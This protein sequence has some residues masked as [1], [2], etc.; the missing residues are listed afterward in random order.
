MSTTTTLMSVPSPYP[1]L[2]GSTAS[3]LPG[4][5][6]T[7]L[8][9][10]TRR[11]SPSP[12]RTPRPKTEHVVELSNNSGMGGASSKKSKPW[13][14]LKV[15]SNAR[16]SKSLPAFVEGERLT[17]SVTLDLGS[18]SWMSGNSGHGDAITS[19]KVIIRG[20]FASGNNSMEGNK[21]FFEMTTEVWTKDAHNTKLSGVQHWPFSISL[22]KNVFPSGDDISELSY[23]LPHTFLER[24]TGA[25]I[26]YDLMVHIV[27][28]KLRPNSNL[29]QTFV[30]IPAIRPDP[31][32]LLRQL[33][34]QEHSPLAGPTVDPEGWLTLAPVEAHGTI[35]SSRS[36]Q[37]TCTLS[38]A[39]PLSYTRNS[40]I[41]LSLLLESSDSQALDL[42]TAN[43]GSSIH[44]RLRRQTR[45]LKPET[46]IDATT[47]Q[48]MW[49][50][51]GEKMGGIHYFGDTTWWPSTLDNE[52]A[53][54]HRKRIRLDGEIS[55]AKDLKPSTFIPYFAIEYSVVLLPFTATGFVPSPSPSPSPSPT[56]SLTSPTDYLPTLPPKLNKKSSRPST[57]PAP[58]SSLSGR[59][60]SYSASTSNHAHSQS[61]ALPT[62]SASFTPR[63]STSPSISSSS[64]PNTHLSPNYATN[65]SVAKPLLS[66][67]VSIATVF[68]KGPRPLS[69]R[70]VSMAQYPGSR[71]DGRHLGHGDVRDDSLPPEYDDPQ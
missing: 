43:P 20:E 52:D 29:Q 12:L 70:P 10:Y 33:A 17:G 67:T 3:L 66:Q 54:E 58:S 49:A 28:N 25:S 23:P 32:S 60:A 41:P 62:R 51:H 61:L 31:P 2:H 59:S 56:P 13:A 50:Y 27:R 22:P 34:Y 9:A 35:F 30:Y 55:L 39:K 47:K 11:A 1:F 38:I 68:A 63:P 5:S 21:T 42:L 4:Q 57:S 48:W 40:F 7:S 36:V 15:Y 46:V 24:H 71:G 69:G 8:P 19:V 53:A 26:R 45:L 14:V 18:G 65:S 37:I 6:T 16:S 64:S 44:V